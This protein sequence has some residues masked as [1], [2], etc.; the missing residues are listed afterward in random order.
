LNFLPKRD[1][2]EVMALVA[3]SLPTIGRT[4]VDA[5]FLE[6]WACMVSHLGGRGRWIP[7][8]KSWT[9]DC[10][11]LKELVVGMPGM[12]TLYQI[13]SF[14]RPV[15]AVMVALI[16]SSM[17]GP[18]DLRTEVAGVLSLVMSLML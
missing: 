4:M 8:L 14:P 16:A 11:V 18:W 10:T 1:R 3:E 9:S 17:S 15:A 6:R 12:I 7:G 2:P 13:S 5:D